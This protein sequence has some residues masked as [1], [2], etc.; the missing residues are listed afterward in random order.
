MAVSVGLASELSSLFSLCLCRTTSIPWV[1]PGQLRSRRMLGSERPS[2]NE[3]Q[4]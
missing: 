4:S 2:T 3:M 1:K